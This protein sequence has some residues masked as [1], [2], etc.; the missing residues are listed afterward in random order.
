MDIR[1]A[2]HMI[3]NNFE[4][5]A[6]FEDGF[7]EEGL[8]IFVNNFEELAFFESG[9]DGEILNSH[10]ADVEKEEDTADDEKEED[11]EAEIAIFERELEIHRE[12]E[13]SLKRKRRMKGLYTDVLL[14]NR[15]GPNAR[16]RRESLSKWSNS[17]KLDT[18]VEYVECD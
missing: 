13:K 16:V 4:E 18:V 7:D 12:M 17:S 10:V 2:D 1:P 6:F 14:R 9:F 15:L 11:W 5:L 3:V 8:S